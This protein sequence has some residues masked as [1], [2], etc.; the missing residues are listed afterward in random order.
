MFRA[1][2]SNN[3]SHKEHISTRFSRDSTCGLVTYITVMFT[4]RRESTIV[5]ISIFD[6]NSRRIY[7]LN[8]NFIIHSLSL[9]IS[10]VAIKIRQMR[11]NLY[12]IGYEVNICLCQINLQML[13][14]LVILFE[15][16]L[17][18]KIVT[19]ISQKF[20]LSEY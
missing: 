6:R 9:F 20:K 14:L 5:S 15:N 13:S 18:I 11:K 10:G 12:I 1:T 16:F 4:K 17:N 19:R 2:C 8:R 7:I 3:S